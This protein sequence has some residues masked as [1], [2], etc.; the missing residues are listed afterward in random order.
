MGPHPEEIVNHMTLSWLWCIKS[1]TVFLLKI[2]CF[3]LFK[4]MCVFENNLPVKKKVMP[5]RLT[6][7]S[8]IFK[9]LYSRSM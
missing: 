7:L 2:V 3:M 5:S 6:I 9:F 4:I 8:F 1:W